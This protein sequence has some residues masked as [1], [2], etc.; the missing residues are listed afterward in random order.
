MVV[1]IKKIRRVKNV[2]STILNRQNFVVRYLV[3][4]EHTFNLGVDALWLLS[5]C[6]SLW[7][8]AA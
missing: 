5:S 4:A 8:C 2:V 1:S 3:R 7:E 6:A